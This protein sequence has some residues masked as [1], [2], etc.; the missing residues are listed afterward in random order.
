MPPNI[1]R[2]ITK[3]SDPRCR[4]QQYLQGLLAHWRGAGG[5][6]VWIVHA[7]TGAELLSISLDLESLHETAGRDDA[8]D[9]VVPD[10]G[11]IVPTAAAFEVH[12]VAADASLGC[13]H[14]SKLHI[15]NFSIWYSLDRCLVREGE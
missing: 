5:R 4:D 8:V 1:A 11:W 15:M 13:L 14:T 10:G 9:R 6:E 2:S 3:S 12:G 7:G